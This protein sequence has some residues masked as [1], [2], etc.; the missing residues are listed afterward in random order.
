MAYFKDINE[1][2]KAESFAQIGRLLYETVKTFRYKALTDLK[3]FDF[4]EIEIG[5]ILGVRVYIRMIYG[6]I[7][8]E[9]GPDSH[10][11][12]LGVNES[13]TDG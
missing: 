9:R 11:T 4:E 13:R 3:T 8:K 1:K 6:D 7:K 12:P 2:I 5:K 10:Q